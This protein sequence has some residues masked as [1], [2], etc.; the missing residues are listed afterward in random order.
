MPNHPS[1]SLHQEDKQS[2][3]A[4][5]RLHELLCDLQA[6]HMVRAIAFVSHIWDDLIDGDQPVS[7]SQIN[8]AFHAATVGLLSNPFVQRNAQAIWPVLE[9]GILNWHGA[10]DLERL[11]TDHALQVAHVTRCAVGDVAVLAASL[12]HGHQ[13]AASMAA[14]LRMLVQQDSLEDYMADHRQGETHA[15]N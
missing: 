8:E 9:M 14:E 15:Q 2:F 5:A 12:I 7:K 13:K 10:N 3:D 11:G 1:F 4:Y 6:V